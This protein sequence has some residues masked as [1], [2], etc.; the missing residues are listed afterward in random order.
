MWSRPHPMSLR[1]LVAAG[2]LP[3][4]LAAALQLLLAHRASVIVLAGPSGAGKTTFLTALIEELPADTRRIYLRGCY[5]TFQFL[6]D[7]DLR[8]RRTV[9]LANEISPHLPVYLWGPA[10]ARYLSLPE[11]GF[12][13][14]ATA[15]ATT[16]DEFVASLTGYPLRIPD[17]ALAAFEVV[18]ILAAYRDPGGRIVRHVESVWCLAAG[19][20]GGLRVERLTSPWD[21]GLTVDRAVLQRALQRRGVYR[22]LDDLATD[23]QHRQITLGRDGTDSPDGERSQAREDG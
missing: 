6:A 9:V 2:S 7:P 12:A 1:D 21:A 19:P 15:H 13:I 20:H 5:E 11:Q 16:I 22:A 18:I 17:A 23:L 10:V 3:P 4:E 8:P 14:A